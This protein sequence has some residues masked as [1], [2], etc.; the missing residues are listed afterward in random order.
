[1]K[2]LSDG[3]LK[4]EKEGVLLP[5]EKKTGHYYT[6]HADGT[7]LFNCVVESTARGMNDYR[8]ATSANRTFMEEEYKKAVGNF[9][10]Q[11]QSN[12]DKL[13]QEMVARAFR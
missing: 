1:M 9:Q 5:P 8:A 4:I 7:S 10:K 6:R 2:L 3:K 12:I 11:M 13:L